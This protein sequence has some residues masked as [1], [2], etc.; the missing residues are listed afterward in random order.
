MDIGLDSQ[1]VVLLK[2]GAF[3]CIL[4]VCGLLSAAGQAISSVNHSTVH[5]MM[6]EGD[7]RAKTLVHVFEE[8]VE[9]LITVQVVVTFSGILLSGI[10]SDSIT[11]WL[12]K[13]FFVK[14][15]YWE[16]PV[17][18]AITMVLL[19]WLFLVL[20]RMYPRQ[21]ALQ[22]QEGIA[23]S[24]AGYARFFAVVTKP[25][26]V[27][28]KALTNL[29]LAITRQEKGFFGRQFS[30]EDVLSMLE[31]GQESGAIKEEGKRMID[32]IFAF[33]DKVAYEV[34]TPRTDV[35][36]IDINAP[37]S[38]YIDDMM[39]MR[40]SRIPVYKD[41]SDNIIGILNLKDYMMKA[42]QYGFENV[43][44]DKILRKAIF[45]PETKKIDSLL[46]E[47]QKKKQ[48]IAILID[49][50]GG[51]SG[52]V[53]LEDLIEEIVGNIDD[54]YDEEEPAIEKI[55]DTEFYING[56]MDLDD[57]NEE[58]GTDLESENNETVGGFLIDILGEIPSDQMVGERVV[59]FNQ[60]TFTIES[61]K[62]RRIERVKLVVDSEWTPDTEE[63]AEEGEGEER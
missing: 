12:V 32:Q 16:Y 26:V 39:G 10:L 38:E 60:Y 21:L 63:D 7:R 23:L 40:Y 52:I 47:L 28:S 59:E 45:V 15:S 37:S 49:E 35:F 62:D 1:L 5:T 6:E 44:I 57:V 50:Y 19:S 11:R 8:H 48:H 4:L 36:A 31:E 56:T 2:I 24:L 34:M 18:F 27:F 53:T 61:V 20:G 42:W 41:D 58:I 17:V 30:E 3:V 54:E 55:S 22:H 43:H 9:F 46:M 25:F 29:F 33:D 14:I 51:F 13:Q